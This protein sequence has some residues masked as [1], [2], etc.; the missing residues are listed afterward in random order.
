MSGVRAEELR[1]ETHTL[2]QVFDAFYRPRILKGLAD[3]YYRALKLWKESTGDPPIGEISD[4]LLYEFRQYLSTEAAR[5]R[6]GGT[7]EVRTRRK[8]QQHVQWILDRCAYPTPSHRSTLR[9]L[10]HAPY[11]ELPDPETS[12]LPPISAETVRAM[13][14]I[15]CA[16]DPKIVYLP[17]ASVSGVEPGDWWRAWLST[18]WCTTLRVSQLMRALVCYVDFAERWIAL[19]KSINRKSKSDEYH[20]ISEEARTDLFRIR[21]APASRLFPGANWE[22]DLPGLCCRNAL[23]EQLHRLHEA[24]TGRRMRGVAFH[25][26]RRAAIT[27]L[28]QQDSELA[29]HAAGHSSLRT[30]RGYVAL[31]KLRASVAD[32]R[33]G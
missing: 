3:D 12:Q 28:W 32:V 7:L 6:G 29:K 18:N 31:Q 33:L 20:P 30:T 25:G 4:S 19:P 2:S 27:E 23:T 13:Y 8:Y 14:E 16:G 9:L 11:A 26:L 10:Q 5:K 15:A 17:R 22:G 21:G 24:A 1:A